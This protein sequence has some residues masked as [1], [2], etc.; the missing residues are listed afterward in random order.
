MMFAFFGCGQIAEKEIKSGCI[1]DL[2]FDNNPELDGTLFYDV[3]VSK[4]DPKIIA[5]VRRLVICSSSIRDIQEQ[6]VALNLPSEYI[7]VSSYLGEMAKV[8]RLEQYRFSGYL[9]SGLPSST[10]TLKGG[11]I[12]QVIETD[13][14]FASVEKVFEANTHG[15]IRYG[16]ELIFS[17]QGHGIVHL[18]TNTHKVNKIISIDSGLRP[19]GVRWTG[20]FY[21]VVCALDDSVRQ[22]DPDG[23]L[24]RVFRLSEK[25]GR[26]GTPQHHCND[27]F[28]TDQSIFVSMFSVAGNWKRGHFDGGIVEFC[29]E[30]G[31]QTVL[32][33]SLKMPHSVELKEDTLM[34][35]ESFVG[36]VL[37]HDF[38]SLGTLNGFARGLAFDSE[39]L[40]VGESKN[41]NVTRMSRG[42]S[43]ASIDTR[44]TIID[45]SIG[46]S[47]S[48]QLPNT[49]SEIHSVVV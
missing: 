4:A 43:F 34:V 25:L 22:Y 16:D 36:A 17:A 10:E 11:G 3:P 19:H 27:L 38:E 44:V 29:R 39:F 1:P 13:P 7:E 30:T 8:F 31:A 42:A 9:S 24:V 18:D 49:I 6:C 23:A 15:C 35:L 20:E 26:Y 46:V 14:G 28:V 41:R 37:G 33:N 32:T 21:F 47:R 40:I 48:I 45:T 2:I 5:R 12:F